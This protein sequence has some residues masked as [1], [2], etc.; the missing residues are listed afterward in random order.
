MVSPPFGS[1][2]ICFYI[3]DVYVVFAFFIVAVYVRVFFCFFLCFPI[4]SGHIFHTL[5]PAGYPVQSIGEMIDLFRMALLR[6]QDNDLQQVV[7]SGHKWWI[8][9]HGIPDDMATMISEYRNSDQN[10]NQVVH[11]GV[12]PH[13]SF[14]FSP[15]VNQTIISGH[16][17]ELNVSTT[18]TLMLSLCPLPPH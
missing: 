12:K 2:I 16:L 3:T 9:N 17:F 13:G 15:V 14:I 8:L 5:G 1:I 11:H 4:L 6:G 18:N 10:T 7:S